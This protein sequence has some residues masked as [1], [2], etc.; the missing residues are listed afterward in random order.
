MEILIASLIALLAFVLAHRLLHQR[1]VARSEAEKRV[2]AAYTLPGEEPAANPKGTAQQLAAAGVRTEHPGLTWLLLTGGPLAATVTIT[3]AMGFPLPVVIGAAGIALVAPRQWL[4]GRAKDRGRQIDQD[5]P[6]AYVELLSILR[7]SPDVAAALEEVATGLEQAK[8]PS[9]L[10]TE[11]RLT[12][13]EAALASIGRSQALQNL[14]ARSVSVSLANLGL[15]LERFNQTG[16]GQGDSFFEAFA[17]GAGNVQSILEARQRAQTK[18]AES[19]QSARLVPV[20]LALT[21]L[22]FMSD[23]G[24]QGAFTLPVVQLILAGAVVV[25]YAGYLIM[26]DMTREAVLMGS[27][28]QTVRDLS[29]AMLAHNAAVAARLPVCVR[30]ASWK[31]SLLC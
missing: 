23:P 28:R 13:Q 5:L 30:G 29:T 1:Q 8:G 3:L 14:Q 25:M 31:S 21:L 24:F 20:L 26:A 7:A 18:A 11:L 10:S 16:A 4:A 2:A 19:L 15:L 17:T 27:L 6:Q 9:A 22:F 12:A